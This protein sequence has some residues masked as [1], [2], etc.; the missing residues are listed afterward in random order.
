MQGLR[1]WDSS[2]KKA[3][4]PVNADRLGETIGGSGGSV[5]AGSQKEGWRTTGM[6]CLWRRSARPPASSGL[7]LLLLDILY[8]MGLPPSVWPRL[9]RGCHVLNGARWG[10]LGRLQTCR[11]IGLISSW[12]SGRQKP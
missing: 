10:K 3:L 6:D 4:F 1:K 7:P 12:T 5:L 11:R 2:D 8:W 9:G